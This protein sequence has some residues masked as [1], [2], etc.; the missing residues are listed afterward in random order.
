VS[1]AVSQAVWQLSR[2]DGGCGAARPPPPLQ[3][4]RPTRGPVAVHSHSERPGRTEGASWGRPTLM[5]QT[6]ASA[7]YA[8]YQTAA[9]PQSPGSQAVEEGHGLYRSPRQ[10]RNGLV[11]NAGLVPL[12]C[13]AAP[14]TAAGDHR[15]APGQKMGEEAGIDQFTRGRRAQL[16]GGKPAAGALPHVATPLHT[17]SAASSLIAPRRSAEVRF[18]HEEGLAGAQSPVRLCCCSTSSHHLSPPSPSSPR[19]DEHI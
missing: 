16:V 13:P 15:H 8:E 2:H 1:Q 9:R 3:P 7:S 14:L 6:T 10:A 5:W 11:V 18:G 17:D 19:E 12:A 4:V